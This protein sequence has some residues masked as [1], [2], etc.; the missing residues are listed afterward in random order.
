L[1][2]FKAGRR[3]DDVLLKAIVSASPDRPAVQEEVTMQ[4]Q[5][6]PRYK[7]RIP[8]AFKDDMGNHIGMVLNVSQRGL[9]VSSRVT[10]QVG[11]RVVLHLSPGS[12]PLSTEL[13]ARVVWK[14]K[15]HR[16]A[17]IMGEG[18]IGLEI[19]GP[20]EG[21][22]LLMRDLAAAMSPQSAASATA[23]AT[24]PKEGGVE[25]PIDCGST[26]PSFRVRLALEG[27]PRTR[28]L[29]IFAADRQTACAE[30]LDGLGEGWQVLDVTVVA[31]TAKSSG[32]PLP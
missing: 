7:K 32:V 4:A 26:M 1:W 16:S 20:N 22:D 28:S 10:P 21:Y 24:T 27:S 8:C 2:R 3:A 18:G 31:T 23:T 19:E 30:A 5:H 29:Q 9:F 25:E 15:V 13:A 17:Q 11:S 6:H 14:R 12:G